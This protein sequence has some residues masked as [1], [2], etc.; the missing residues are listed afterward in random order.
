MVLDNKEAVQQAEGQGRNRKEVE[1]PDH[2]TMVV[3]KVI[4]D[5]AFSWSIGRFKPF[6]YRDTVGS[7]MSK[8]S[9]SNSPW[10]RGAPHPGLSVVNRRISDRTSSFTGGR[11]RGR[12]RSR[13]NSRNP[14]LCRENNRLGLHDDDS[15][16]PAAD[17]DRRATQKSRS[18]LRSEGRGCFRLKTTSC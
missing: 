4:Q 10:M 9:R 17:H 13:Q 3:Q 8:P 12:E 5:F 16:G 14:A 1:R 7:E 6:R 2:L 15:T 11:P 18:R